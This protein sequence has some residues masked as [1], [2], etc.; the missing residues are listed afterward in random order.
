MKQPTS[1]IREASRIISLERLALSTQYGFSS[2]ILGNKISPLAQ[3]EK[4]K[5]V[6][7]T[8]K[9]VWG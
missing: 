1:R 2:S 3:A 4:L 6:V 7:A 5:L 8:A 9:S